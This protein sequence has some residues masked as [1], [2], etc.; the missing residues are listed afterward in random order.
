M[1][2]YP[3]S[4]FGVDNHTVIRNRKLT[5]GSLFAGIGGMDLGLERAGM[6]CKWQVEIDPFCQKVLAKHWPHVKR[7][8]DITKLNGSELEPVDCICGGFPCQDLSVAG[9][10]AGIEGSRSG[11]WFEYARLLGV[12][13]PSYVLIENVSGLLAND[14]MRRVVGELAQLGYVGIWRSLRASDFGAAHQRKRVFIVAHTAERRRCDVADASDGQLQEPGW[15]SEG[16][17][18]AGSASQI[19]PDSSIKGLPDAE[20]EGVFGEGRRLQGRTTPELC[21]A[22]APGPTDSRWATILRERPDLAPSLEPPL[23]GVV[24]GVP[25]WLDRALSSRTKRLS[26]LGNAVVPQIAEWIGRQILSTL[27]SEC[28]TDRTPHCNPKSDTLVECPTDLD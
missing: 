14:A 26:K 19:L 21:G 7:Y 5:F 11:L 16:R 25:D 6:E 9:K 15:G 1:L 17:N 12:L 13:R 22:F 4:D 18:G 2:N 8:G 23:R 3:N 10:Q 20:Q 27:K 24:D 28:S